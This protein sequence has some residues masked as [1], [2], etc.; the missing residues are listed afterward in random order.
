MRLKKQFEATADSGEQQHT[1]K[2]KH[3]KTN[4][5]EW[6]RIMRLVQTRQRL[7]R[8]ILQVLVLAVAQRERL[9]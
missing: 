9:V 5:R 4:N 1:I 8:Q 3:E 6:V 7:N 2:L